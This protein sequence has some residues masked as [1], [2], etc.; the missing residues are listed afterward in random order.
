M[1]LLAALAVE[2]GA[3]SLPSLTLASLG[4]C[5]LQLDLHRWVA[6]QVGLRD[7]RDPLNLS[8]FETINIRTDSIIQLT[9]CWRLL[10]LV[11][12]LKASSIRGY[13]FVLGNELVEELRDVRQVL[14]HGWLYIRYLSLSKHTPNQT[15]ALPCSLKLP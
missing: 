1:P 8:E 9:C 7:G 12:S 2:L 6:R 4:S 5:E 11:L 14:R 10:N 13:S 3:D 15:E